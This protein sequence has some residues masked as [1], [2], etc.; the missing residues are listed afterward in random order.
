MA[1]HFEGYAERASLAQQHAT[2]TAHVFALRGTFAS[3]AEAPPAAEEARIEVLLDTLVIVQDGLIAEV[4]QGKEAADAREAALTGVEITR[5]APTELVLPGFVDLHCHP[6]Q[7]T[8][9]GTGTDR[10]LL[11][12]EG[13]LEKYTYP[14]ERSWADTTLAARVANE[15]VERGLRHGI[16][17][18]VYFA[19]IHREG[20]LALV[21]ACLS[22]GQRAVVGKVAMD[23]CAPADYVETTEESV[24]ESELFIQ[25]TLEMAKAHP[26]SAHAGGPLVRP[27]ITPRFVPTCSPALLAGLGALAQKYEADGV[28]VQS[29]IAQS[30]DQVAF[31]EKLHPGERGAPTAA[32]RPRRPSSSRPAS[33]LLLT[34]GRAD[35]TCRGRRGALRCGGAAHAALCDGARHPPRTG[36]PHRGHLLPPLLLPGGPQL[37][38][39]HRLRCRRALPALPLTPFH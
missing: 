29:H 30:R 8:F 17:T 33:R 13:W 6:A 20:T 28:L 1:A 32:A 4:V 27:A 35:V 9:A 26:S 16:T 19:T 36:A 18:A 39:P 10:P 12:P 25:A 15:V 23:R 21:D 38:R 37:A 2:A 22:R 34:H 11:G 24:S 5:L 3:A 7:A 31:T 14:A